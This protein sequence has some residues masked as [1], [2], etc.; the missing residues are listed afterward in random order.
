MIIVPSDN[1]SV[2]GTL[3]VTMVSTAQ[4]IAIAAIVNRGPYLSP[5]M[6]PGNWK[7]A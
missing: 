2:P 3:A 6:P 7:I 4:A 1:T 5:K